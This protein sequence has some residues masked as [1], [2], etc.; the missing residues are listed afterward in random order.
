MIYFFDLF[1]DLFLV[2]LLK[3]TKMEIEKT[4]LA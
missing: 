1:I 4:C 2:S 3:L